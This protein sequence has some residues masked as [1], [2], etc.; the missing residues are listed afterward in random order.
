M[1]LF[2][3]RGRTLFIPSNVGPILE[4]QILLPSFDGS[5]DAIQHMNIFLDSCLANNIRN[6]YHLMI[7]FPTTLCGDAFEWYYSLEDG[8]IRNWSS[9][10]KQFV[11]HFTVNKSPWGDIKQVAQL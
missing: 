5:T 9:L 1:S 3:P 7:L 8:S 4:V 10:V 11:D 6:S 2:I